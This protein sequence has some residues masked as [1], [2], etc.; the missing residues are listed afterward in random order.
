M[1][2]NDPTSEHE[3]LAGLEPAAGPTYWQGL[4]EGGPIDGSAINVEAVPHLAMRG[5][6]VTLAV[7]EDAANVEWH[8]YK[9]RPNGPFEYAGVLD[10]GPKS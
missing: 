4:A 10:D 1:D 9:L 2:P 7:G 3:R 8:V 6:H 5:L